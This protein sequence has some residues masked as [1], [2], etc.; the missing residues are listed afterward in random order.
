[1]WIKMGR[2]EISLQRDVTGRRDYT[3]E[4]ATGG[5]P[6]A[7]TFW[8]W[9]LGYELVASWLPSGQPETAQWRTEPPA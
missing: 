2:L 5:D 8:A 6:V 7:S 4:V 3:P 9:W 1:M